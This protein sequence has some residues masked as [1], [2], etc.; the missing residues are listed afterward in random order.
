MTMTK[1]IINSAVWL[2]GVLPAFGIAGFCA[3]L[4]II[5]L[6]LTNICQPL[7][8]STDLSGID[9]HFVLSATLLEQL[10]NCSVEARN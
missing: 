9:F 1:N 3:P 2:L 5:L 4:Y 8:V 10:R 6:P 7:T